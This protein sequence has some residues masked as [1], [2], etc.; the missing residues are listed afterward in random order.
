LNSAGVGIIGAV[1]TN[2]S[3][4]GYFSGEMF[5]ILVITSSLFDL[6]GASLGQLTP[7]PSVIQTIYNNQV[8]AY[9]T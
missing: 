9:G 5:E 8:S 4:A 7:I 6:S 2:G 3:Y 1:A